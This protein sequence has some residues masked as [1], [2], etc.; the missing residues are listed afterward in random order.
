MCFTSQK[1]SN[2]QNTVPAVHN[3]YSVFM[4]RQTRQAYLYSYINN[5]TEPATMPTRTEV[6]SGALAVKNV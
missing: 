1:E 3:C 4:A 6:Y 5:R 2:D